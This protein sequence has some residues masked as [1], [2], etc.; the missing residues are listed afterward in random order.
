MAGRPSNF[1]R[2]AR[3]TI[4]K[5]GLTGVAAAALAV[6]FIS[7]AGF[8]G[9]IGETLA[10]SFGV[11]TTASAADNPYANL[12]AYP[13][14]LSQT[15]LSQIRG[16]LASTVASLEI[17]RAAT[18]DKIEHVRSL[19]MGDGLVTFTPSR[20]PVARIATP[21][22][23]LRLTLSEPASFAEAPVESYIIQAPVEATAMPASY[24]GPG[25]DAQVP[26]RDPHLELA[27][28]ILAHENF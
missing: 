11:D 22:A 17:T 15:E 4:F 28:L 3:D 16:Q 19:A 10:S 21:D 27:D 13:A 25:Y 14:P 9:M 5:S 26:Y 24:A 2:E 8:G 12:P 1:E 23:A 7:P 20:A 6:T 18:D